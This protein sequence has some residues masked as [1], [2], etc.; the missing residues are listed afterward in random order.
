MTVVKLETGEILELDKAA[1]ER[2][3]ERIRLR[4]DVITDNY[5]AVMPMIRESIEKRDDLALGY[6][7]VGEY[8]AD[9]FGGALTQ[10]GG[11]VRREVVQE[12]T[13]AGMS[14]RAIA[15]VVGVSRQTIINDR[16]AEAGVKDLTPDTEPAEPS[17]P[18]VGLD[19]KRYPKPEPAPEPK[20]AVRRRKP[21]P[22]AARAAEWELTKA[23]E[24]IERITKDDRF[25]ANRQTVTPH[26]RSHLTTA[27]KACQDLLDR[28][29]ND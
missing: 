14:T 13:A 7:S 11:E 6:R 29:S 26:L 28:I 12:L 27:V 15:P 10:L 20:P 1:A 9:R 18:V 8:V 24:R 22:E 25:S 2:R 23:I 21:L 16:A 17:A 4:L 3:A 19:G 5:A